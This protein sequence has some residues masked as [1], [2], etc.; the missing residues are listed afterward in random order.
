M[1]WQAALTSSVLTT[2]IL[3]GLSRVLAGL[4]AL[5]IQ[6]Y[7][8]VYGSLSAFVAFMLYIYLVNLVVLIGAHVSAAISSY[9]LEEVT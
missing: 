2:L 4:L 6:R 9:N 8:L 1:P 5:I 7:Q 3:L